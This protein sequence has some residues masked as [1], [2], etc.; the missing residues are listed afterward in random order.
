MAYDARMDIRVAKVPDGSLDLLG[1]GLSSAGSS[2]QPHYEASLYEMNYRYSGLQP[3]A[4]DD[5]D[6]I[7]DLLPLPTDFKV[8]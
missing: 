8:F 3:S 4:L 2:C 6:N 1:G 7:T 5:L